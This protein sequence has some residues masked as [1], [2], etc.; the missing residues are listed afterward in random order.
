[1]DLTHPSV[2]PMAIRAE[3]EQYAGFEPVL[4]RRRRDVLT[5]T[6]ILHVH[7]LR[8]WQR[9]QDLYL[10]RYSLYQSLPHIPSHQNMVLSLLFSIHNYTVGWQGKKDSNSHLLALEA[11]ILPLNYSPKFDSLS[12]QP[13]AISVNRTA[14]GVATCPSLP[15]VR[16]S[17]TINCTC[18]C[19][20]NFLY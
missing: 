12:Y 6:P 20:G 3:L 5:I 1:M 11:I 15:R 8:G 7:P 9:H 13:V 17:H 14:R 19:Y 4:S 10:V 2:A 16:L 18:I